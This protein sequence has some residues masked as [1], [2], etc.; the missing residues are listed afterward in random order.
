MNWGTC[1]NGSNN[2]HFDFLPIMNDGRNFVDWNS[3]ASTN[4]SLRVNANITN[5]KDYRKYLISNAD[6]IIKLNQV[7]ACQQC[8]ACPNLYNNNLQNAP[9][10]P[11]LYK[12]C[13]DNRKPIGYEESD[14][15]Q[16]YLD[17]YQLQSRMVAPILTQEQ[18]L[19][20]GYHNPN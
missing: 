11:F 3:D 17:K 1:Y 20:Q 8:C 15:K 19:Q 2:I 14:L 4:E 7:N 13:T 10:T 5:N 9:N 6:K 12:S 16:I 18:Y